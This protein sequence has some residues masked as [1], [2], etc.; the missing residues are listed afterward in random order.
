MILKNSTS[1]MHGIAYG[2]LSNQKLVNLWP[3]INEID[4]AVW[5]EIEKNPMVQTRLEAGI[6]EAL[7]SSKG[8]PL[9]PQKMAKLIAEAVSRDDLLKWREDSRPSV[10]RAAAKRYEE[11]FGNLKA[12]AEAGR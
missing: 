11:I 12:E 5:A 2:T 7:E 4:P 3:G 8:D 10:R 9:S 6:Y 1:S